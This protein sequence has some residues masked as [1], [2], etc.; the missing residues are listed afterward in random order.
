MEL[1]TS[2]NT[3]HDAD[4]ADDAAIR[5]ISRLQGIL[6]AY[7]P[8]SE[9]SRWQK[10]YNRPVKISAELFDVLSLFDKWRDST[11]GALDAS[12]ELI[13]RVWKRSAQSNRLPAASDLAD[14]V[15]QVRRT[16]WRLDAATH[17]ATHLDDVPLMLN[18]FAKSYIIRDAA[19]A[20]MRT[21]KISGIV[22]NIGG[23]L[24]VKGGRDEKVFISDPRADAEN[25]P[26]YDSILVNDM[27]VAT[28][29]NYR[30]G[31][32]IQGHWYSHIVDPRTGWPA[33]NILSATVAAPDASTAGAL[34]T[35]FNVLSPAESA[36]L[37]GRIPG[38]E[39]LILTRDGRRLESKGWKDLEISPG[40]SQAKIN[41]NPKQASKFELLINLEINV[42]NQAFVK[43]PYVAVWVEDTSHAP[44]RT[45]ALWRQNSTKYLPELKS[46]FLKYRNRTT[47]DLPFMGSISSATRPAGKYTVKW[48]GRDENG[49]PVN[50]GV[51]IIKIEIAREHG[52]YQLIRQ[53]LHWNGVAQ[54]IDLPPNIEIASASL[55][56]RKADDTK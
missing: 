10:T 38:C 48:D 8:A 18:S 9:F 12:A 23:D 31:E 27:A 5:E 13:T 41:Q 15:A 32:N 33:D 17:T 34:A 3:E 25:D 21:G 2:A 45:I 46:W 37:G 19:Q 55:D 22:V 50:P 30:R 52:T 51:Y 40:G 47:T 16:H 29:G 56:Y 53:E 49:N 1:K 42:Q 7:E 43:R 35:A 20:A 14:A 26:A 6:S 4:L 24:V 36:N 11:A 28:S 44:V 39:Y 54:K